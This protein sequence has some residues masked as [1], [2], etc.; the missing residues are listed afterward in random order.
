MAATAC[1]DMKNAMN[2]F[3]RKSERSSARGVCP[4]R[5]ST[6]IAMRV[7]SPHFMSEAARMKAP[8]MKNT[9]SLPKS[10]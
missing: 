10:A 2:A 4:N 1:S 6:P 8:R 9:A 7:E 5:R 3:I